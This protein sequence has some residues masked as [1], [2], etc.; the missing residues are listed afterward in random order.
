[1]V[2]STISGSIL[3]PILIAKAIGRRIKIGDAATAIPGTAIL[4][5]AAVV[6]GQNNGR[7]SRDRSVY[8]LI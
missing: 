5:T 6:A 7:R 1:M 2:R 8:R 3:V 4:A